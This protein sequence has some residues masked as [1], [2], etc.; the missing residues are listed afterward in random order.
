MCFCLVVF[1]PNNNTFGQKNKNDAFVKELE[2]FR[3]SLYPYLDTMSYQNLISEEL[4]LTH[5]LYQNIQKF[6]DEHSNDIVDYQNSVLEGY[7]NNSIENSNYKE[8][9]SFL[10]DKNEGIWNPDWYEK[11]DKTKQL[12][13]YP[14]WNLFTIN[15]ITYAFYYLKLYL[16]HNYT[17]QEMGKRTWEE[18][19]A[20]QLIKT[21]K[22]DANNWRIFVCYYV[23]LYEFEYNCKNKE[24][25]L[26]K[27]YVKK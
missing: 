5:P 11:V 13:K 14:V 2:K 16:V 26:R 17:A 20:G 8:D 19:I 15:P 22:I 23:D 1:I 24:M 10:K 21:V 4:P 3:F 25:V 18:N 27:R 6:L 9:T 12:T 7:E